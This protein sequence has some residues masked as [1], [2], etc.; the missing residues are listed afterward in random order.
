MNNKITVTVSI[1]M[2]KDFTIKPGGNL[3]DAV[4]HQVVLPSEA[5]SIIG[6]L[7][8]G[9]Q[10]ESDLKGWIVDDFEVVL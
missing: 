7:K 10:A 4:R 2:S 6:M 3:K 5:H 9:T 8:G 1:T